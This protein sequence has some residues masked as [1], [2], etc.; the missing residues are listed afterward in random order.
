[1]EF[2]D[3]RPLLLE[4]QL[5]FPLYACAREI[6]RRYQPLLEEI[7]LTYTQYL[8]MMVLWEQESLSAG[9]LGERLFLDSGTLTPMLKKMEQK[10][11]LSRQRDPADERRLLLTLTDQGRALRDRALGIPAAL[12]ACVP[13][14]PEE[15]AALYG[16]LY[17]MLKGLAN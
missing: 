5:C 3:Y 4:N 10:G 2:P 8:A 9:E 14:E 11:L 17:K 12:S 13:L 16:L 6:I 15:A 1:M 7:D